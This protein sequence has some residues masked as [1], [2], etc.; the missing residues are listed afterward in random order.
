MD[1]E[2]LLTFLRLLDVQLTACVL[3]AVFVF[4]RLVSLPL[5]CY[6]CTEVLR[7]LTALRSSIC[8][9]RRLQ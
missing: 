5:C 6:S 3:L 9:S 4:M 2:F 7:W 8:D 1:R